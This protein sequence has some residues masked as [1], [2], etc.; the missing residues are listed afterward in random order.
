M[1]PQVQEVDLKKVFLV[2][3]IRKSEDGL[4]ARAGLVGLTNS[5]SHE[6]A[7]LH[8]LDEKGESYH[9]HYRMVA[10]SFSTLIDHLMSFGESMLGLFL[11]GVMSNR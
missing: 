5:T 7:V 2:F 8:F 4:G 3:R 10:M 6:S 11:D 9:E 1:Y